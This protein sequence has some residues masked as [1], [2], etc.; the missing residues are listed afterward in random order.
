MDYEQELAKLKA[1]ELSGMKIGDRIEVVAKGPD[2]NL[3]VIST[4]TVTKLS[5]RKQKGSAFPIV[6]AKWDS[7]GKEEYISTQWVRVRE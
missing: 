7:D 2:G 4:G 5:K 6:W 3:M 1:A